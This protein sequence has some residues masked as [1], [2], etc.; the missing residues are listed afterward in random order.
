[1]VCLAVSAVMQL[2]KGRLPAVGT[3]LCV[4]WSQSLPC[5][6]IQRSLYLSLLLLHSSGLTF[7]LK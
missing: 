2:G 7:L 1:M 3:L 4:S 6:Y 5:H